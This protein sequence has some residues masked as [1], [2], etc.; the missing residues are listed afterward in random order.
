[1]FM[2]SNY[3][4]DKYV[5]TKLSQL[6]FFEL[7]PH[8]L[9]LEQTNHWLPCFVLNSML[10]AEVPSPKRQWAFSAIRRAD[11]AIRQYDLM[12]CLANFGQC[13]G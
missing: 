9:D 11:A 3:S 4:K 7:E 10:T 5:F 1:M 13:C 2:L 8:G 6:G 12:S